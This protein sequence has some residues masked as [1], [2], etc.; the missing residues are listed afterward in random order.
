[1]IWLLIPIGIWIIALLIMALP[2]Y[3]V[4]K[5]RKIELELKK[6][7]ALAKYTNANESMYKSI[8]KNFLDTIHLNTLS[9]V[10]SIIG[11]VLIAI[12]TLVFC[13]VLIL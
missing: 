11:S 7:A 6:D 12:G 3:V 4:I 2:K 13:L 9:F 10:G 8:E 5:V 1:M